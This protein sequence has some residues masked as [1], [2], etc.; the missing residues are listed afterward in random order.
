M[1]PSY[2]E[3]KA[4]DHAYLWH[5]FTQMQ[6]WLAEDPL[7]IDRGEGNYLI[8]VHGNAYLDGVSSLWCNVHGHNHPRLNAA[9]TAQLGQLAHST[10]LGLANVPSILLAKKLVEIAPPGLT[11]VFYSDAGAT[12]VEIALKLALQYWQLK[13]AP[14]KVKFVSLVEAYHGDTLGAMSVGYSELFH[15]YYRPLLPDMWRLT[16][17]HCFRFHRGMSDAAALA[18]AVDEARCVL[19]AHHHEIAALIIEP[20]MQGAAGMWA[21]PVAYVQTLRALTTEYNILLI[22]DE[23]ATGFGRTGRM[24]ACE[25]AGI[26]PDLFCVAKGLTGGYLPLAATL[27]TEEIFSA[28]LAPYE[29]FKTFFHGHTYTGNPLAC[30]AALASLALFEEEQ[31]LDA[32]ATKIALLTERLRTDYAPLPHVADIR[33]WGF[34]VGIELMRDPVRKVPYAAAEKVGIRVCQAAR[35]RGVIIRPL[36]NVIVLMPP[37]SITTEELTWLVDVVRDAITTVTTQ[38]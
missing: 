8:D 1:T 34:M 27:T 17:P 24:F 35:A 2:A 18:A 4:W 10:L 16:P 13:G 14:Q 9:I 33:Q 19:A 20:L 22:C 26:S 30:A 37:L 21:Q 36:G 31:V 12:A 11:R 5:P 29:E 23:V 6:D 7:I 38:V 25:H 32:L 15:R 28:F 3:L